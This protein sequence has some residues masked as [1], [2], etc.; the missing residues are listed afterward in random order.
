V[1]KAGYLNGLEAKARIYGI[2]TK[3]WWSMKRLEKEVM[4]AHKK[5]WNQ[6]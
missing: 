5:I 2:K 4:R 3:W 6:V 1:S